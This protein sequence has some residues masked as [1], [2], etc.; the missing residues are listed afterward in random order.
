MKATLVHNPTAG[1]GELSREALT[2]LLHKAG[3]TPFYQSSKIGELTAVLGEPADLIVVA[4]GDG[5]VAKVLTQM[6]DRGVPVAILPLGTA[7]NIASS[8]GIGGAVDELALGLRD[9][10]EHKLD[11]GMARGPWGCCYVVEG[12]G[13]GALVRTAEKLGKPDG[14]RQDRLKAARRKVRKILKK[15]AADRLRITVDG[16]LLPDRQLMVEVLNIACAGPRLFLAPDTD[17][18]DGLIEVGVL[19]PEQ[20]Q[21]M[22]R[23]LE[24]ERPSGPPPMTFKRGRKVSIAWDGTPLHVDD[25]TP[26]A[27]GGR[28]A[29]E[30]ELQQRAVSILVPAS[31]GRPGVP[32]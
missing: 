9:A 4:G 31:T 10:A 12:L 16:E 18:G 23:W 21:E 29:V 1:D 19:E 8:F 5:T 32:A 2:D 17:M 14:S 7:N 11:M 3:L 24:D 15:A 26:P 25:D 13:L 27:E 20:R 22:R 30:L 6:P 28:V